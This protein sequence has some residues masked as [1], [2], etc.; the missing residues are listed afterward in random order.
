[1][2]TLLAAFLILLTATLPTESHPMSTEHH[3]IT[4]THHTQHATRSPQRS[5]LSLTKYPLR[6]QHSVFVV[7]PRGPY[8]TIVAALAAAQ[9]GDTIEV[10]G[11][12]Y[13]G[14]L[15]VDKPVRLLGQAG[16]TLDG[17][18]QGTVLQVT[19]SGALIRGFIIRNSGDNLDHEDAGVILAAPE[20][21]LEANQIENVLFG[22]TVAQAPRSIVRGNHIG[23]KA[24]E[25]AR[26][27][28]GLRV[29]ESSNTLVENNLLTNGRDLLLWYSNGT[30]LRGNTVEQGR[31]G[32]H[33]MFNHHTTVERNI[34]RGNSVGIYLMYSDD[35]TITHNSLLTNRGP[36]GYGL[37]LKDVTHL[38]ASQNLFLDNRVAVYLDNSLIEPG[39]VNRFE[40]NLFAL[41]DIGLTFLPQVKNH[42]FVG[43]SFIENGRQLA[44]DGSGQFGGN[45]WSDAVHGGNYWSDYIGYDADHDGRGDLPYHNQS[46]FESLMDRHPEMRLF[47]FSPAAQ[48]IDL[49]ARAFPVVAP[50]PRLTDD[51]PRITPLA[52][53][54]VP[55]P[56]PAAPAPLFAVSLGLLGV[57]LLIGYRA[58]LNGASA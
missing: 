27:G 56:P 2:R 49:A 50:Q 57:A 16:A 41:N 15:V 4:S 17:Q 31:Y 1:M 5:A 42:L 58:R 11:G 18:G 24:L 12:T 45:T 9:S 22:V 28:D 8:T 36:S 54:D 21:T 6:T 47:L 39:V 34:L 52:P 19:A 20:T 7:S 3:P 10:R 46:L 40:G 14:G 32:L 38:V 37:G 26:R 55:L 44:V 29:W 33:F 51:L 25:I 35:I 23:G 43:N 53:T 13:P 48:A 30:I